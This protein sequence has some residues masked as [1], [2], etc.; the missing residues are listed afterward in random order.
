L[1]VAMCCNVLQRVADYGVYYLAERLE[2]VCVLQYVA[3]YCNL[4]QCVI[5]YGVTIWRLL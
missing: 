1:C 4:L 3:V 2:C 5:G